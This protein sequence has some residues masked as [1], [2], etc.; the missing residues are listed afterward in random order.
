MH[1]NTTTKEVLKID[2]CHSFLCCT[3]FLLK[4]EVKTGHIKRLFL[5]KKNERTLEKL[6]GND[7]TAW[8]SMII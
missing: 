8:L 6:W 1:C 7:F 4:Q 3:Y 5:V 2:K